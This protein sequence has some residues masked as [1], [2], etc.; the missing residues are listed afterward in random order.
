MAGM[1]ESEFPERSDID[2]HTHIPHISHFKY[3]LSFSLPYSSLKDNLE[4][5]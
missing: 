4:R 3:A 1:P 2:V 5:P